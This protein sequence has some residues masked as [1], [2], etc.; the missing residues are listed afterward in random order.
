MHCPST[1]LEE[2]LTEPRSFHNTYEQAKAELGKDSFSFTMVVD[3]D[4]APQKVAQ[5]VQE[6]LQTTLPGFTLELKVEISR[7]INASQTQ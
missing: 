4:D 1:G 6:Q 5:V 7:V 3:A 2:W